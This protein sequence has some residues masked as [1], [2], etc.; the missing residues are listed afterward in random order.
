MKKTKTLLALVLSAAMIVSIIPAGVKAAK[1]PK[2]SKTKITVEVGST[3]VVKVKNS[4]AK[5]KVTWKIANTK[6]AKLA[7]KVAKGKKAS[8]T[9]LGVSA[10]NTKLTATYKLGLLLL[11]QLH[12][13]II[14]LQI[15]RHRRLLITIRHLLRTISRLLPTLMLRLQKYLLN[16][17]KYLKQL[18]THVR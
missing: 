15:I 7:K 5:A 17:L 8:A 18:L 4:L 14:L 10:G 11:R 3:Q 6:I 13:Q 2:L 12:R 1:A 9:V 16:R